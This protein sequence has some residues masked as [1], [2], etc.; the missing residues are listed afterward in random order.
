MVVDIAKGVHTFAKTFDPY[1]LVA[2]VADEC[3]VDTDNAGWSSL[4]LPRFDKGLGSLA[5]PHFMAWA[6]ARIVRR[7]LALTGVRNCSYGEG[8]SFGAMAKA[9]VWLVGQ[10]AAGNMTLSD[11]VPPAGQGP[12]QP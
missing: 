10:W 4:S 11:L 12:P 8:M 3:R 6:N 1:L 5:I 2:D 7:S 9:T